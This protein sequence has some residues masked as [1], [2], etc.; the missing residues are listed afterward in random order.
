[1]ILE[2][3]KNQVS[4]MN[5]SAYFNRIDYDG[6]P[7]ADVETLRALSRAHVDAI[8]FDPLDVQLGAPVTRAPEAAFDKI[9]NRKR[10]GW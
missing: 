10:G 9:V 3:A 2:A 7:K 4:S 6:V 8:P 5:L 1:M